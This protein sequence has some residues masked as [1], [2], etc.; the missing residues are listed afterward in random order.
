MSGNDVRAADKG[1]P[2]LSALLPLPTAAVVKLK[3]EKQLWSEAT[4][5][6]G[7]MG[8]LGPITTGRNR[9]TEMLGCGHLEWKPFYPKA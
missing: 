9:K 4:S 5:V 3:W 7:C 6:Y 1:G 2:G 8:P